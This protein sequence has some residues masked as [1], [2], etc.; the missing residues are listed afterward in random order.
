MPLV[1]CPSHANHGKAKIKNED[2][3]EDDAY[4]ICL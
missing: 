3:D 2:A 1:K 4:E